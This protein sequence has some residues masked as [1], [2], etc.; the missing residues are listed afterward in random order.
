MAHWREATQRR[1]NQP[2]RHSMHTD[3]QKQRR[4]AL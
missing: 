4:I 1:S 3:A 2:L